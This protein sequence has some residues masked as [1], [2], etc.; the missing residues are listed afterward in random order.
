MF[1]KSLKSL[2][3][4][5]LL[6]V[7]AIA[8]SFTAADAATKVIMSNDNNNK[9]LKGKTFEVLKQE[10]EARL[11]NKVDV[12]LHHS[13]SLFNQKTQVQGLQLGSAHLISPTA[14]IYSPVAPKLNALL[15]PFLLG[16]PEAIDAALR[17]DVVRKAFIPDM[18]SK[19]ITP[20]AVWMNGPRSVG[21]KGKDVALTPDQWK[22]K[23]IRV[24][25]AP[26]FVKT[27][28]AIDA[29]VIA[30]S[31]SEVPTALQTGVI[32]AAEPTPNA[33]LGS[34]IY[35]LVDHI[36]V[37]EYIYSFYLVGANKPWWDGL[38][39]DVRKGMQDALA[40]ATKWNWENE[41][42]INAKAWDTIAS[43]GTKVHKLNAA[44]RKA[45][46]DAVAP[47]WKELGEDVVGKE[48]MDRLRQI[49]AKYPPK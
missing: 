19:N 34:G 47:V 39:P 43:K 13:G 38:A 18:E 23:K 6:G 37:N 14:G 17:D 5:S 31:W 3:V 33:W 42:Q 27:M 1:F 44:Q 12:E 36:V 29:N 48:V 9:G 45:W 26:I 20:V 7:A 41:A 49:S 32:D 2:T 24:Q 11:G 8:G 40:A 15:L 10:I 30:M 25:S 16:S 21:H 35:Q 4:A 22:G 46:Q 28:E